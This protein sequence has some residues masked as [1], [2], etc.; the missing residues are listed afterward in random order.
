MTTLTDN[1]I[2][3]VLSPDTCLDAGELALRL[4]GAGQ[5]IN[6][7][8]IQE[9]NHTGGEDYFRL[10]MAAT[11]PEKY[12]CQKIIEEWS[13]LKTGHLGRRQSTITF[14]DLQSQSALAMDAEYITNMRTAAAAVMGLSYAANRSITRIGVIGTGRVATAVLLMI[15][16]KLKPDMIYITGRQRERTQ[17]FCDHMASRIKTPIQIAESIPSCLTD[18]DAVISAVPSLTPIM[19]M[20]MISHSVI[21]AIIGGDSRTRQVD[22]LML[23]LIP[24]LV[25]DWC[26]AQQSGEFIHAHNHH[27]ENKLRISKHQNGSIMTIADLI[28]GKYSQAREKSLILY[29]TGM[30]I[31]DLVTAALVYE[32]MKSRHR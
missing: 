19:A 12:H 13:R 16:S 10:E 4:Y 23:E 31:L 15:D 27:R 8:R 6:H 20:E 7:P 22:Q 17:V 1:D 11:W 26:Q 32:R 9:T 30:A 25:D 28:A 29:F 21:I 18:S 2:R 14:T 3:A 5:L 24:I